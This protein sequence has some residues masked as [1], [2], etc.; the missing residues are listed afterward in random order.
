M[1][2]WMTMWPGARNSAKCICLWPEKSASAGNCCSRARSMRSE[3]H[4][5]ELQ[6][7]SNLVCRLLLEKNIRWRGRRL[8]LLHRAS[9]AV[10]QRAGGPKRHRGRPA[11]R[12][13]AVGGP[14]LLVLKRKELIIRPSFPTWRNRFI[15]ALVIVG[16]VTALTLWRDRNAGPIA[17]DMEAILYAGAIVVAALVVL[18]V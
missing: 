2:P 9:G 14:Q 15:S 13:V 17:R 1:T 11:A 8:R 5:S 4:T 16:L 6:S 10:R 18:L 7:Q 3:E 12:R